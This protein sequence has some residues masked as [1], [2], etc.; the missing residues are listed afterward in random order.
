M[1]INTPLTDIIHTTTTATGIGTPTGLPNGVTAQ[2]VSNRLIILG[3]PTN[4]GIFNYSV[5]LT[6]GCGSVNA[7][8]TITVTPVNTVSAASSTPTLCVYTSLTTIKHSTVGATGIDTTIGLPS[9]LTAN[10]SSDTIFITG[11][12]EVSGIFR[13]EVRLSGG[14]GVSN[15]TGTITVIPS[16]TV[17]VASSS[18]TICVNT[19]LTN[20]THRTRGATGIGTATGLPGGVTA[21]WASNVLTISGKPLV[22]GVYVYLIP[23]TGGCDTLSAI[24]VIRVTPVNSAGAASSTPTLCINTVLTNITHTTTGVTGIGS[25]TGLPTGV[26]ASWAS[27]R[28]TLS[29]T[30]TVS[31]IFNYSILLTGE[32]ESV[33]ATGTIT[34]N[35]DNAVGVASSAPTLFI[36][37]ALTNITHTTTGAT[38]IGTATGLP[39]GVSAS[40][41][42]N[43]ITIGGTPTASGTFSYSIPLIG[44]CNSLTATGTIIVTSV[45]TV[46]VASSSPTLCINSV[47]TNITHTTTGATGIGTSTGLP[48]GVSASWLANV[49]SIS[50]TPTA[51]GIFNYSIPLTGNYDSVT[52]TGTITVN[53]ANTVGVASSTPELCI[54]SVLT[55]ITH[56][57]TGATGIGTAT[58]L[59]AGVSAAWS[60]NVITISGTPT[61]SGTFSYSI[62]LTGGCN[63]LSATGTVIVTLANTVS[64]ASSSPTLCINSALTNITHTT[65]GATGIGTA[66]G[67]PAGV[68]AAWSANVITISGTPTASGTFSYSIPLTGGCGTIN[69]T[70]TILIKAAPIASV[71]VTDLSGLVDDDGTICAGDEVI[72]TATGGSTF[73]WG[74]GQT[75]SII[76]V[77]PSTTTEY[78]VT[79][80]DGDGCSVVIKTT[81]VVNALPVPVVSISSPDCQ[82]GV[83]G[84][85]LA[86]AGSSWSY[87]WS[88]GSVTPGITELTQGQYVVTVTDSKGCE[89]SAIAKLV[90]A[91]VPI[92][93]TVSKADVICPGTSTGTISLNTSGGSTPYSYAWSSNVKGLTTSSLTNLAA[94]TYS[95]TVTEAGL[96]RCKTVSS[97][98]ILEPS[99]G[100]QANIVLNEN[101]GVQAND[102][103]ICQGD[104]V[105]LSVN[106]LT[107]EGSS[108]ASYLWSDASASKTRNI[109]VGLP[110]VYTVTV[111][112]SKGCS[113][114]VNTTVSVTAVNT[115]SVASATPTLCINAPLTAITHRTSG[116]TSIGSAVGLP[117]GVTATWASNNLSIS[118]R[119]TVTGVFNYTIPLLGG[120]DLLNATGTITVS[121]VN[122]VEVASAISSVC[123]NTVLGNTSFNTTGATGIGVATGLP[124]GLTA[125]WSSNMLKIIGI[126]TQIGTFNYS[127]PLTGGCGEISAK[128]VISVVLGNTVSAASSSPSICINAQLTN[129]LHSTSGAT[130]IG[131]ATGL[132]AGV[133][134]VWASNVITLSGTPTQSGIYTYNIPLTGGCGMVSAMG[135]IVV[136]ELPVASMMVTET[137]GL[138]NNDGIICAGSSAI[139]SATG[140]SSFT[141]ENGELNSILSVSPNITTEYSV[142]VTAND[143]CSVVV[144]KSVTVDASPMPTVSVT[145]PNCV[146]LQTGTATAST[147]ASWSYLWSNGASTSAITGLAQGSYMVTVTD[148]KGCKGTAVATLTDPGF[149]ITLNLTKTDVTC[150]GSSTGAITV[151]VMGGSS[152]YVYTWSSNAGGSTT[153]TLENLPKGNYS[154][155][156]TENGSNKCAAVGTIDILEPSFSIQAGVIVIENSGSRADDGIIC[157]DEEATLFAN[158]LTSPDAT[159]SSYKWS[160]ALGSVSQSIS[161]GTAGV[162]TVTV[163]DSKGCTITATSSA[164]SLTPNNAVSAASSTPTTCVQKAIANITHTTTGATG[165][166]VVSGLPS[167]VSATWSANVITISGTPTVSGIFTYSIPLT[168]GCGITNASGTITVNPDNTVG[169]ASSTPTLCINTALTNI[170]HTTIGATGIG[171]ATGLPA[172]VS[173]AWF[174]NVITISGTPTASGTFSYSIPLTGGCDMVKA[175]GT[176]VVNPSITLSAAS[177]TPTLCINSSLTEIRHTVTNAVGIGFSTGLPEGVV[178]SWIPG[179]II[180]SG[181]PVVS[182][183]FNYTISINGACADINATGTITVTPE[184]TVSAASSTPTLCI[185][186]ALT[187]ITHTTTG[188][189]GIGTAT[190]LPAGVSARWASNVITI[191]GA[192]TASGTFNYTIPLTSG[193]GSLSAK[194][195]IT[196][197]SANDA[198]IVI[199]DK[200][201]L[202]NNDGT[203]CAGD[204][205]ILIAKGGSTFIW[206]GGETS[207]ILTVSPTITT[208]YTVSVSSENGCTAQIKTTI[209]VN[210]LPLP[211]ITSTNPNCSSNQTGTALASIGNG[212]SYLWSN[213][214]TTAGISGLSQGQYN[215][216]VTD[217]K[218][219]KGTAMATL[220]DVSLPIT[221]GITK[222]DVICQGGSNGTIRLN[223]VGG[224]S[225]YT[226]AWSSN[227]RGATTS[228]V[229]NL[230][231]GSYSVTVTEGS[232]NSCK[233]VSSIE[234]LEPSF[235]VQTNMVIRENSGAQANDGI[236][237]PSDVATITV[238]AAATSGATI[239]SYSW[240]NASNSSS[241]SINVSAAGLYIV[242][243]TD[244]RGCQTTASNTLTLAP[245]NLV[246]VASSTPTLCIDG[247]LTDIT[248]TTT[249]ATGIGKATGLPDGVT[250][251]WAANKITITGSPSESGTFNYMI[252][253]IGGCGAVS[254]TGSITVKATKDVSIALTDKSGLLNNDGTICEGESVVLNA[255]GAAS[256]VWSGG[257]T[258]SIL[259]VSPA[260]SSEYSVTA[261][262]SDGCISV[263]K[264]IVLVNAK[265][266]PSV[267]ATNTDCLL[268][269][270]G[271][272]SVSTGN[273]WSYL[274]SNGSVSPTISGLIQGQYKVTVTD[275]KGCTEV[276]T[277]TLTDRS[278]PLTIG[279]SK[280]DVVCPGASDGTISLNVSNGSSPY[281]FVW[282][283]NVGGATAASLTNLPKGNYQ[284]TVTESSVNSCKAVRS[285]EI[286]EP[287]FGIQTN[288][289]VSENNGTL[290]NEGIL[291]PPNEVTLKVN[292]ETNAG[293]TISSYLWNNA[294]RSTSNSI[295]VGAAGVYTVTVTDSRGCQ[296]TASTILA[297]T[298][299]N[300]VTIASS[301]PALCINTVL[302]NITH[303]TS[304]ATG[305]GLASGLPAGVIANWSANVLTISGTPRESGTF[306][307]SIPLTGGCGLVNATGSITVGVN[308]TVSAPSSTPT[309]CINTALVTI[310][311][312]TTGATGI[313]AATGLPP[314]INASWLANTIRLSG[315]PAVSGTFN[316]SIPLTGGCGTAIATGT[317]T[318][319]PVSSVTPASSTPTL[320]INRL[321]T[322][323]T[324]TTSG[325]SGIG[326]ATGL[327][328]GVS[329][330]WSANVVT[331]SGVPTISGIF[332]YSIA[333]TG[334]CGILNATGTIT[335]NKNDQ[336]DSLLCGTYLIDN[337]EIYKGEP[338]SGVIILSYKGGNGGDFTGMNLSSTGV[339]GLNLTLQPGKLA[340]GNGSI[341][342][343]ATG[344]PADTGK[345]IFNIAFGAKTCIVE[346]PV[347][348]LLPKLSLD[349]NSSQLTPDDLGKDVEYTGVLKINYQGGNNGKVGPLT[350][351]S[352]GVAG[353]TL[354]GDSLRLNPMG[355]TLSYK[356]TGTPTT[357]GVAGFT[358]T[359]GNKTCQTQFNVIDSEVKLSSFFTPNGDGNND[360]WENPALVFYP[361]SLVYIFDRT[362]RLL[363][364]YAGDSLGW[365]GMIGQIPASAGDYWYVIQVT[366]EDIR[367]GNFTLIK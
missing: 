191:S 30:P 317:I 148:E 68:S 210:S 154:V 13:Y 76:S 299:G 2:W 350:L 221:I 87:L 361:E 168:G 265:P 362:G 120:C 122:T 302:T 14:C 46:S 81:V 108:I 119:P 309:L 259:I 232:A 182:G 147:N 177:S 183:T 102:G 364:E 234:I 217:E 213:G 238:I 247:L 106:T 161:V 360:R 36:N 277:A 146:L 66:T 358:I 349:C 31:G 133:T 256:Y 136:K 64:A 141:W 312:N 65:T 322:N 15:A 96:N 347:T 150:K 257:E 335:V 132:P 269:Q 19:T 341:E 5:P 115:V 307:Y 338:Y 198:F 366:K 1:C 77:S 310:T 328:D 117:A 187:N 29:G 131:V 171:T 116:V 125:V 99:F 280:T 58:G 340:V 218:G 130:G 297:V 306:N 144:K 214:L 63:S 220:N 94:G 242:T 201:G 118:G 56:T 90:D 37:T 61:A 286:R 10:W 109:N 124:E 199:T 162:Y 49:I 343:V 200:S 225:P 47:L 193:C 240:N 7:T 98:D 25:T 337:M 8:G 209:F 72:L 308:N 215:V 188:A 62:P 184:N 157:Q 17:S 80:L 346:L 93:V 300:T 270:T 166:G 52:A 164:I 167:G 152:P 311:H 223:V 273:G 203:I 104:E 92:S 142:T 342:W 21:E 190:G 336:V 319:S 181:T 313:G 345:A 57:T 100:L 189:T 315:S 250:A 69:A 53:P 290:S 228:N 239:S 138:T 258:K 175:T 355:G 128:G 330:V 192:P 32:C 12:P 304:G 4:S 123:V 149:P 107:N 212:W 163:T 151:N 206:N 235:G 178:A 194:G 114:S 287:S 271:S 216:T 359:V 23:L 79:V 204:E 367:R 71:S 357:T 348:L 329:A 243:V 205:V 55:N 339:T 20:I 113:T 219:C 324:H 67:L 278:V 42:S 294:Q 249:G 45:N 320:N 143:G 3:R 70:G 352:T 139:L 226:Y 267:S 185:N 279:V 236:I 248:H 334:G 325:I 365:D 84:S 6:G 245:D 103:I 197:T 85:A 253:L 303:T 89:G 74:G 295:T 186:S 135:T 326:A 129:I 291:C 285:I 331:I 268:N 208:G 353:L 316:Y 195:T 289:V 318:V 327:P 121:P 110:G 41:A 246:G 354:K 35:P 284:V 26:L 266:K 202:V 314:G 50:G 211:T 59:P 97:I 179:G 262:D 230:S 252:P 356:V 263:V 170:T 11:I 169:A 27:D 165:I 159:I 272:A 73:V 196:V 351:S 105:T 251:T 22:S 134:A 281:T 39:A 160:D 237:C 51:S 323:I 9:G 173:A 43:L 91:S 305:I 172:G 301:T 75:N 174:A 88:N 207:S 153:P 244:S 292:A 254:A 261:T 126:P 28:I 344:V 180:I 293:A 54:N 145:N 260:L 233:V 224:S 288:I 275:E 274:W 82:A 176:I 298:S 296:T 95:V 60:A 18:P 229:S 255:T 332:N 222:T 48:A 158:A 127:I 78:A 282:S 111:T 140:G 363:V 276:A 33:T 16:N 112:D 155:S 34:V 241:N 227:A 101:S 40:W 86:S 44:G 24:G 264:T 137:S 156:V 333:L 83:K 38:G 231:R 321:L 283:S